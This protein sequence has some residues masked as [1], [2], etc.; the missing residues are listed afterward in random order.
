M[1]LPPRASKRGSVWQ[2]TEEWMMID[3]KLPPELIA[4]GGNQQK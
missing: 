4:S 3:D 2:V 1:Q